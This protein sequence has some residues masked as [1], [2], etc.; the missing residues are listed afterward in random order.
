MS[1]GKVA[2]LWS[3]A[4]VTVALLV[5]CYGGSS[6]APSREAGGSSTRFDASRAIDQSTEN[7]S[8]IASE[9]GGASSRVVKFTVPTI[10]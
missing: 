2:L 7:Q 4:L 8:G 9:E 1:K 10:T 5:S 6:S 3:M